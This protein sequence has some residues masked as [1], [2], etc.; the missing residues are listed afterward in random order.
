VLKGFGTAVAE[1]GFTII[2]RE[3]DIVLTPSI[4]E[5]QLVAELARGGMG[6]VYLGRRRHESPGARWYAI[7]VLNS[8]YRD[9]PAARR[10]MLD[11]AHTAMRVRHERVSTV[12]DVGYYEDG[13]Y[14]VM[15]YIEGCTLQQLMLTNADY[16]PPRLIVPIVLDML[17]G[18]HAAH[19]L[20]DPSGEPYGIVHRD[21]TPHNVLVGVNGVAKVGDFGIAMAKDRYTTT[22]YGLRKGKAPFMAP[23]QYLGDE[24]DHRVDVWS[25]GV[26]AFVALTGEYPF[27]EG[28]IPKTLHNVLHGEV[29]VPSQVGLRPP[30]CFD[31]VIMTALSRRMEARFEDAC[32][33]ADALRAVAQ[34]HDL[35]GSRAEVAAWVR[36]SWGKQLGELR[37]K[38]ASTLDGRAPS[39]P[40][41]APSM[42]RPLPVPRREEPPREEITVEV[43]VPEL[44]T[45]AR[46]PPEEPTLV[47]RP[48]AASPSRAP[49]DEPTV[50]RRPHAELPTTVRTP[51][52][53]GQEPLT[54]AR[55]T[56]LPALR[57]S[58]KQ[59]TTRPS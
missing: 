14:L 19:T 40:P 5:Y 9:D 51:R 48:Q 31:W 35:L 12:V 56:P 57:K 55:R 52:Q 34:R 22:E 4:R 8:R 17:A 20:T 37:V 54:A 36:H 15:D 30:S 47:R 29:P 50:V 58:A 44:P 43:L 10:M 33:F 23:E 11:E 41:P 32:A 59:L 3:P 46:M 7:K 27:G 13:Y 53:R 39:L 45:P 2:P 21:A 26:T 25:A 16:R 24:L 42:R 38:A 18:L 28:F 6:S 49:G 1:S